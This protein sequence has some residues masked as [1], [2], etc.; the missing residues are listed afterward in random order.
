MLHMAAG[1]R[2]SGKHLFDLA[3]GLKAMHGKG[4]F[5]FRQRMAG[6][7]QAQMQSISQGHLVVPV[8][9]EKINGRLDI[10]RP[11]LH[12]LSPYLN[13]RDLEVRELCELLSR[14]N[15]VA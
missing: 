9:M 11:Q 4:G 6:W 5:R 8:L 7:I 2:K 12:P 10:L 1:V 3:L 14:D 13:E 15:I